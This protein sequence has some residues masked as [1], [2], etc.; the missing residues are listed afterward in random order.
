MGLFYIKDE[1]AFISVHT[2]CALILCFYAVDLYGTC[3]G[4]YFE[5]LHKHFGVENDDLKYIKADLPLCLGLW[6]RKSIIMLL[7][8]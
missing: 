4:V 8:V 2:M 3:G 7:T 6:R 1:L 5:V